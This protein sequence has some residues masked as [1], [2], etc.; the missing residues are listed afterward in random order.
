MNFRQNIGSICLFFLLLVVCIAESAD[1][2]VM[3]NGAVADGVKDSTQAFMA[4]WKAACASEGPTNYVIPK[5]TFNVHQVTFEGP[6]KGNIHFQVEGTVKADPDPSKFTTDDWIVFQ[7]LDG[8]QVSGTGVFDGQGSIAW[9]RNN[10]GQTNKCNLP[11]NIRFNFVNNSMISDITS[12]NSKLFHINVL[13]CYNITFLSVH[14]TAP[15]TSLNTDGIHM[16]LSAGV[17]ITNSVIATGDDC[18][19]IGPGSVN[20]TV[21]GVTC[22]PG[23]GISV[24]SLGKYQNEEKVSGITVRNCTIIGTQNGVRIKTWPKSPVGAASDFI[25]EDIIMDNVQNP[26]IIDQ[27]Y[28]PWNTCSKESPSLVKISHVNFNK[29]RGTSATKNVVIIVC[30]PGVPCED[31]K[32]G[33]IDLKYTGKDGPASVQVTNVKP[34]LTGAQNPPIT[35]GS[36]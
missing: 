8:I 15:G 17:N 28:C 32:I 35:I 11:V 21:T 4:T 26:I 33:D 29:I 31:V 1:F 18:V 20:V 22:G 3:D 16:G 25:F 9:S 5:G 2:N 10:C 14:V 34:I 36:S 30:S 12:L 19:S 23:H 6:C 13:G 7:R 27:A 24:G